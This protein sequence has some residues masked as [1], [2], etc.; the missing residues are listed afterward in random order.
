MVVISAVTLSATVT[1]KVYALL[2]R[3]TEAGLIQSTNCFP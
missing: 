3:L 2:Q 1:I